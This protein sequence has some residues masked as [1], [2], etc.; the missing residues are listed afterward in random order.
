MIESGVISFATD[1]L[2]SGIRKKKAY[3][4]NVT[5]DVLNKSSNPHSDAQETSS[6]SEEEVVTMYR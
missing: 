2:K 5:S 6:N 4:R 1:T 3:A